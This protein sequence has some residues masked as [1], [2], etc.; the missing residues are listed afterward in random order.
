MSNKYFPQYNRGDIYYVN[1][2]N[3]YG[4]VVCGMHP[5]MIVQNNTGNRH[6]S[7]IIVAAIVTDISR[8]RQITHISLEGRFGL[9]KHSVLLMEQL[10]TVD[11]NM[12]LQ[13][14]GHANNELLLAADYAL[15]ASLGLQPLMKVKKKP[16]KKP[17]ELP[18]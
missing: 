16:K 7:T 8:K 10:I 6:S 15:I 11:K 18:S 1:F 14:L 9:H 17:P 13:Y 2:G 4:A 5:A 3:Q 12:I